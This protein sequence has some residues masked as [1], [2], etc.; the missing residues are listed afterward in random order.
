MDCT[1]NIFLVGMP[2]SGKSTFGKLLAEE[3]GYTF[4]DLDQLIVADQKQEISAIFSNFGES[5]F[6]EVESRLLKQIPKN[7]KLL[8]AT[9]GGAPCFFDNMDFILESGF[10]IF[11]DVQPAE[12]ASRIR[13]YALDDRPLLSGLSDLESELKAKLELR[14]PFYSRAN[15]TITPE[16][17]LETFS[18][19]LQSMM[20]PK[21]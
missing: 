17:S 14:K 6:R 4:V 18:K 16:V 10:T 2:S 12:L 13:A 3:V 21:V 8:I 9:G 20:D 7:E 15:V 11:L 5:Y 1:R 19:T